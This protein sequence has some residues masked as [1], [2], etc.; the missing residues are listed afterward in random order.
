LTGVWLFAHLLGF[1]IW[2][3]GAV[4]SMVAGILGKGE[5]RTQLAV[6]A[7]TQAGLHRVLIGPGA[8]LTVVSGLMLT[9]RVYGALNNSGTPSGWLAV[10]Q[11]AGIIAALVVLFVGVPLAARIGRLDPT[12]AQAAL[13]DELRARQVIVASTAGTLGLIA[14]LGGALLRH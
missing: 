13:F 6:V 3:G 8:L 2:L 5:P 12:G 11:I 10:M 14:L 7:R 1:V 4:A 9:L